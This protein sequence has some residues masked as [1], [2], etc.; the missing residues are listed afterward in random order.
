MSLLELR[1]RKE[2]ENLFMLKN[3]NNSTTAD[4]KKNLENSV[5]ADFLTRSYVT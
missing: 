1:E 2:Q 3:A 5:F 4:A